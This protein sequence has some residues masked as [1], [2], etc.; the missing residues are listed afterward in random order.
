VANDRALHTLERVMATPMR[1]WEYITG[2]VLGYTF[3]AILQA[4][5]VIAAATYVLD[6]EYSGSAASILAV[7]IVVA[8]TAVALAT[9][10]SAFA[11]SES[12]AMQM[13][14]LALI[15]Q[16]IIGGVLFPVSALPDVL[17][18]AARVLPVTYA[19]NALRDVMLRDHTLTDAAVLGDLA[20]LTSFALLFVA[21]G[22]RAL[23]PEES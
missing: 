1:R 23:Q 14:P 13:L 12:E 7:S 5:S 17:Q 11:R 2:A 21:L 3:F 8:I 6:A 10:L 16:F 20:A 22:T 15:P 18:Q 19:V 9:F 4:I